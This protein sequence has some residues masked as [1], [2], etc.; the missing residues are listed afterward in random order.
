MSFFYS[1][2]DSPVGRLYIITDERALAGILWSAEA[3]RA[4]FSDLQEQE[5]PLH[6]KVKKQLAE[7]FAGKRRT[8]DLPLAMNGTPFQQAVWRQLTKIPF[9]RTKSYAEIAE[10]VK[11]PKA[12]RAVGAAN[13]RN[14]IS[15][16]VPCHRVIGKDG[17]L[18]GF[19][20]GMNVK[21]K[22]L[23]LENDF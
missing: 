4:R 16:V 7:Y 18:T 21:K 10:A 11:S 14:P 5:T 12:V 22:L 6:R 3:M 23:Q 13:G 20:G 19:A 15:I 1:E 9:G 8:F 2:T 17:S